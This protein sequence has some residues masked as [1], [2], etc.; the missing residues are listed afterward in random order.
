[1]FCLP[2]VVLSWPFRAE[3][4]HWARGRSAFVVDVMGHHYVDVAQLVEHGGVAPHG[5]FHFAAVHVGVAG[6][7]DEQRLVL[8]LGAAA[9]LGQVEVAVQA[10]GQFEQVAVA[11][12]F[13]QVVGHG[14]RGG[15]P[16]SV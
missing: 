2:K 9:G 7:V 1:M 14:Q 10:I 6:E 5:G 4:Y 11:R 13:A 15:L 8:G 3:V 12:G 16:T